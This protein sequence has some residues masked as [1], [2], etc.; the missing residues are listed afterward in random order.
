MIIGPY[1]K[2]LPGNNSICFHSVRHCKQ[3]D[4]TSWSVWS[5]FIWEHPWYYWKSLCS[6]WSI[7]GDSQSDPGLTR[8]HVAVAAQTLVTA[9]ALKE[10]GT[11]VGA[12]LPRLFTK[13]RLLAFNH[14]AYSHM[15]AS[16]SCLPSDCYWSSSTSLPGVAVFLGCCEVPL[17]A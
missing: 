17:P 10:S 16:Y 4:W 14:N 2:A 8:K 9:S 7:Y 11:R 6:L 5:H 1:G 15:F 12:L 3:P 13:A